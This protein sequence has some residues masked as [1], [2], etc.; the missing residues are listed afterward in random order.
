MGVGNIIVIFL[1]VVFIVSNVYF[2]YSNNWY[3]EWLVANNPFVRPKFTK[4]KM[5][6]TTLKL[7]FGKNF[8]KMCFKFIKLFYLDTK[9]S[10]LIFIAVFML[11][12]LIFTKPTSW[13][14]LIA[15]LIIFTLFA[16]VSHEK[17]IN[18]VKN[19]PIGG[20]PWLFFLPIIG[21]LYNLLF[22]AYIFDDGKFNIEM[23]IFSIFSIVITLVFGVYISELIIKSKILKFIYASCWFIVSLLV[24]YFSLGYSLYFLK[25]G[26][27][28]TG[29]IINLNIGTNSDIFL[30]FVAYGQ[31]A[32]SE[33]PKLVFLNNEVM[34]KV[35][36]ITP[37][38][39]Y[40][41][42]VGMAFFAI[43]IS[44]SMGYIAKIVF[45]DNGNN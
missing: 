29:D 8:K 28:D 12:I 11:L 15:F 23:L 45:Q 31:S 40:I 20:L 10:R 42:I 14:K 37:T 18:S 24:V 44:L 30:F 25:Y 35:D 19:N 6:K 41:H 3:K 34:K 13:I 7:F 1:S 43:F 39:M 36:L 33:L 32:M 16:Y 22:I 27:H 2:A 9:N 5:K 17:L 21:L 4:F 38:I 26:T